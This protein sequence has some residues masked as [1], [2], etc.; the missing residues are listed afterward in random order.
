MRSDYNIVGREVKEY[1]DH[2]GTY[3]VVTIKYG[4]K[5]ITAECGATW[6]TETGEDLPSTPVQYDNCH[7]L[8][9]GSVTLERTGWDRLYYFFRVRQAQRRD[10]ADCEEDRDSIV[11]KPRTS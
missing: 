8:P 9:M 2:S 5:K 1:A 7:N 6:T 3:V 10:R 11:T 4:D